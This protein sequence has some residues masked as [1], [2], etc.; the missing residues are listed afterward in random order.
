MPRE[1]DS[2]RGLMQRRVEDAARPDPALH[3]REPGDVDATLDARGGVPASD[4]RKGHT[5]TTRAP[6]PGEIIG[7]KEPP[8]DVVGVDALSPILQHVDFPATREDIVAKIGEARIPVS[9][10]K[11]KSVREVMDFVTPGN[12]A[13]NREVE[14]AVKRVW[15]QVADIDD[16]GGHTRQGARTE[17]RPPH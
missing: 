3:V 9:R 1:N 13:S 10:T 12:F 11:A 8:F 16:R 6:Y 2:N 17:K 15:D 4:R 5:R 14:E 7:D